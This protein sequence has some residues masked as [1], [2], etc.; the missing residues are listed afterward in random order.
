MS[1]NLFQLK[2]ILSLMRRELSTKEREL[3]H[4]P[5]GSLYLKPRKA[6]TSLCWQQEA[7]QS[8]TKT[9]S[10]K[11]LGEAQRPIAE[12]IQR[13][14]LLESQ[15]PVLQNNIDLLST[16]IENYQPYSE[17]DIRK[18]LPE[19]YTAP[20]QYH[21]FDD[22]TC[23]VPSSSQSLYPEGLIHKNSVGERFRSKSEVQISELLRSMNITYVYEPC[24]SL[25]AKT[26]HPDFMLKHPRSQKAIL[27][28]YF[29]MV[30]DNDYGLRML[31]KMRLYLN[32]G[33]IPGRNILF[34]FET[35]SS[36]IDLMAVQASIK[37]LVS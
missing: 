37:Q 16:C 24:L 5:K 1:Q 29:G 21:G 10:Q 20:L 33:Y 11:I 26:V 36:G 28:E 27:I 12:S 22:M 35:Q 14:H 34:L 13:R 25:G 17:D 7:S 15:I 9:R 2:H 32:H 3:E 31:E 4:L 8:P 30:D 6:Y 18:S 23:S 19:I